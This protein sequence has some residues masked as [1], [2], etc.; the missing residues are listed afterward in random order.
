MTVADPDG[1]TLLRADYQTVKGMCLAL[2]VLAP[3]GDLIIASENSEGL[4]STHQHSRRLRRLLFP[5][6]QKEAAAVGQGSD[7]FRASQKNLAEI[8][9]EKFLEHV[10]AKSHADIDEWETEMLLRAERAS[11]GNIHMWS[12]G[13]SAVSRNILAGI[14]GCAVQRLAAMILWAGGPCADVLQHDRRLDL[15]GGGALARQAVGRPAEGGG[16]AGGAVRHPLHQ[17]GLSWLGGSGAVE[18]RI[19]PTKKGLRVGRRNRNF[20]Q[21][22]R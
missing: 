18:E 22:E 7:E 10:L 9:S 11:A 12:P 14:W 2:G 17:G 15:G 13:L 20:L 16:R 6:P 21:K 8:G 1:R 5:K 3:G 19:E 4:V